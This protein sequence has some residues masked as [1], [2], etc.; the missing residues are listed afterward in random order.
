MGR[1]DV[2]IDKTL[3]RGLQLSCPGHS[4]HLQVNSSSRI[5]KKNSK[6]KLGF[7]QISVGPSGRQ[8][9]K[10]CRP[11]PISVGPGPTVLVISAID[12]T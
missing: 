8:S 4:L 9:P 3:F 2:D 10:F 7:G 11:E 6:T 1:K 12:K 5:L